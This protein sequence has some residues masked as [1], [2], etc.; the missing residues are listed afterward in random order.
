MVDSNSSS[1]KT[2]ISRLQSWLRNP[3]NL[4]LAFLIVAGF[5]ARMIDLTDP[6]L[7]YN[8]SRQLRDALIS[9]GIYYYLDPAADP[10]QRQVAVKTLG[11][12]GAFEPP[13]LET[14]VAASYLVLGAETL[15]I[16]RIFTGLFWVLGGL[17]LYRLLCRALSPPAALV[18]VAFFLF[19]P[20]SIIASRAFQPDP[21]MVVWFVFAISAAYRWAEQRSWRSAWQL[22]VFGALALLTKVVIVYLLALMMV[23]LVFKVVG[24]R[25]ALKDRQVWL[26][27][28]VIL[29]PAYLYY[30]VIIPGGGGYIQNWVLALA[31]QIL[32]VDFYL[33]LYTRLTTLIPLPF[34]ILS[35]I[36]LYL[37]RS[38][39]R[40]ILFGLWVGYLLYILSVPH[41]ITTHDYYHL[42][43]IPLVAL[44]IAPLS[45]WV[46]QNYLSDKRLYRFTSALIL[47][48]VVAFGARAARGQLLAADYHD[49]PAFWEYIGA[50][51]PQNGKTIALTQ[52]YGYPLTYYGWKRV[53]LWPVSQELNL[54]ALRGVER[55][56]FES[57]F[58]AK[59]SGFSFFLVTSFSQLER[60]PTLQETLSDNFPIYSQGDGYI[61]FDLRTLLDDPQ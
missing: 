4:L 11:T 61:I 30:V 3:I 55:Q 37:S 17:A 26:I 2:V 35:F 12:I 15:W 24:F 59:I 40:A 50:Q 33:K 46:Y 39:L 49:A 29:L 18:S 56:E 38:T 25:L 47:L 7:D 10:Q 23:F 41:Q 57:F 60:Q 31:P 52:Q 22:A 48:V 16:S 44:S 42:Q 27:A 20:F 8:P 1:S 5:A 13:I 34:F 45:H 21:L 53:S 14:L 9:R 58:A 6:P 36:G 54:S 32:T 19:L 51:L 28:L 43:L